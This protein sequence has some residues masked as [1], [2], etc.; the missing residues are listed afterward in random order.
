[1]KA[2][3]ISEKRVRDLS[4]I[5]VAVSFKGHRKRKRL[6]T[7]IG[8]GATGCLLDLWLSTAQNHPTGILSD[9][10]EI[11][12][13]LDAGY[14]GDPMVFV[15]ALLDCKLIDKA[16]DGYRLHDWEEHQPW[17]VHAPERSAKA[18]H[19]AKMRWGNKEDATSIL[20][21]SNGHPSGN[22][23]S[24][25]PYPSPIPS[26]TNTPPNPP[27]GNSVPHMKIL[28]LYHSILPTLHPCELN[29]Q[30]RKT[31]KARW[32]SEKKMQDLEWWKW[33][34]EGVASCDFLIGKKTDFAA[35]FPWLIGPRNMTKVLGGQYQN[36]N[37]TDKVLE[38]WINEPE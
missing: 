34:F 11:D 13:A 36:R 3:S 32:N 24:P 5:R 6:K 26:P 20:P 12:I 33:Y 38:D 29:D 16:D 25:I 23:P 10:D 17:V 37:K 7:I 1:M 2:L 9:M 15:R 8:P 27:K 19:A 14:D 4:D 22:A 30:L 21:A 28:D 35:T 31:I 18:K